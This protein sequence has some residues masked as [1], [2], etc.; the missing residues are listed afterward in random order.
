MCTC[1]H[2]HDMY[3][4]MYMY[5]SGISIGSHAAKATPNT[6]HYTAVSLKLML[7]SSDL[8]WVYTAMQKALFF[9]NNFLQNLIK[10]LCKLKHKTGTSRHR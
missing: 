5:I 6:L 1:V 8:G 9:K 3:V 10:F 4:Y 2:V 7:F